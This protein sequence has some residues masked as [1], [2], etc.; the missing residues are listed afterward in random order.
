MCTTPAQNKLLLYLTVTEGRDECAVVV[1][2]LELPLPAD[3]GGA[4]R[5]LVGA[6]G[7]VRLAVALPVVGDAPVVGAH[8]AAL[9]LPRG[10]VRPERR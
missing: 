5:V 3:P 9:V 4:G 2:A 1:L 6:V 7:A 8:R 10:A